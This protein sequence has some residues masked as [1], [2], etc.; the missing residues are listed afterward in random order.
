MFSFNLS[1]V[2]SKLLTHFGVWRVQLIA[3]GNMS[4]VL[5]CEMRL[6]VIDEN[7]IAQLADEATFETF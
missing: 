1:V 6:P 5:I 7:H 2:E 4:D 3:V